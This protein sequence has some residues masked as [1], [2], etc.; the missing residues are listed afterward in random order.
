MGVMRFRCSAA[1]RGF[2]LIELLVVIAIIGVLIALLLPAVQAA[3]EAA[4]RAQCTNNLKQLAL[5]TATYHEKYNV[6][7]ADGVFLGAAWGTNPPATSEGWGWAASWAVSMLPELDQQ[8]LFAAYNFNRSADGPSNN[9]VGFTQLSFLLCPSDGQS[10][11]VSFPWAASNYHGNH[12]GPGAIRNWSGTIVQNWAGYP[13]Q[14]WGRDN[15]LGYFGMRGVRDGAT[16]T[17]LFSEKLLGYTIAVGETLTPQSPQARRGMFGITYTAGTTENAS[18]GAGAELSMQQCKQ[19][20]PA[21]STTNFHLSGA[22]WSLSY[23]WHTSNSAYVHHNTPNSFTCY[24]INDPRVGAN[25]WGGV[26]AQITATSDHPAGVNVAM[27]DGSVKFIKDSVAFKVWWAIGSRNGREVI[28][29]NE[30]Q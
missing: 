21:S 24:A 28:S 5:A 16:Q 20:P 23:P 1:R 19:L 14:W 12:G 8:P 25:P 13:Q 3:R 4:R 22:H 10:A 17:A 7:P 15:N 29:D 30:F 2:T 27:C 26:I 18:D 9:T 6:F 11:P